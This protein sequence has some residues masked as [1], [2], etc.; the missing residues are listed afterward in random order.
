MRTKRMPQQ[1]L[2]DVRNW[3]GQVLGNSSWTPL[4]LEYDERGILTNFKE[5]FSPLE[6]KW[7][8]SIVL[9]HVIGGPSYCRQRRD[10]NDKFVWMRAQVERR[11]TSTWRETDTMDMDAAM[12]SNVLS[13][14][15]LDPFRKQKR[16]RYWLDPHP[17]LYLLDTCA[18]DQVLRQPVMERYTKSISSTA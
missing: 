3:T 7:L 15:V 17:V 8:H 2:E 14:F 5:Y 11:Q 12:A 16:T 1:M 13:T 18:T 9:D 6:G 10:D 4:A